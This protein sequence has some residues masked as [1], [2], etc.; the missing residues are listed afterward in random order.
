MLTQNINFKNFK[1]KKK[2][3]KIANQLKILLKENNQI[4]NSFGNNYKD[5]FKKGIF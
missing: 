4:L 2:N 3:I 1:N 5:Y